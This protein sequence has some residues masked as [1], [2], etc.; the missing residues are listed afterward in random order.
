MNTDVKPLKLV[1]VITDRTKDKKLVQLLND[2]KFLLHSAFLGRGTAPDEISSMLS[3]GEREKAVV[4]LVAD[5]D[6]VKEL[7]GL[8]KAE[9]V[10]GGGGGLAF[11]VPLN[12]VSNMEVVKLI[13]NLN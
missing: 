11:S 10:V 5:S 7:F 6:R 1:T 2:N 3:L 4:V 12:S 9:S 8:L 13:Q